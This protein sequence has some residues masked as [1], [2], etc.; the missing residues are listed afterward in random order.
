M[1]GPDNTQRLPLREAVLAEVEKPRLDPA[2]LEELAAMQQAVLTET[3]STRRHPLRVP[4]LA[5]ACAMLVL[6]VSLLWLGY[7]PSGSDPTRD[8]ALE[9]AGNHLKLK[10]PGRGLFIHERYAAFLH[11]AGLLPRESLPGCRDCGLW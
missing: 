8:I 3:V 5:A 7:T 11:P 10:P 9:V 4:G 2:Q 1:S 6:C